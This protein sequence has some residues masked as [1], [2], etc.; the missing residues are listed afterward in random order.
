MRS[1]DKIA[2]P[3]YSELAAEALTRWS[4]LDFDAWGE[5]LADDVQYS[6]P[7]GD[8]STRT[9]LVGKKALLEWWKAWR[10]KTR[11]ESVTFQNHNETPIDVRQPRASSGLTG[12]MVFSVFSSAL[13]YPSGTVNL[14]MCWI[15]HFNGDKK[16]DRYYTYYDRHKTVELLG[17]N[18]LEAQPNSSAEAEQGLRAANE[19]FYS[20][21]NDMFK[22]E[23]DSMNAI[24]SHADDVSNQGPFG[25]RMDGWDRVRA[26]FEKEAAMKL[27]G[28]VAC[29]DLVVHAGSDMGYTVCVEV[30]ENMTAG[31]KP[32]TVRHRATNVFRMENGQ[33]RL[34]HHHTDLSPELSGAVVSKTK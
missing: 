18:L 7:D 1:K 5:M 15:A 2:P 23:L 34:I 32:V 11:V 28:R 27:G 3:L 26:Q 14:R 24:W 6:F 13:T 31:G 25:D 10:T 16:I 33:W 4:R 8:E 29:T 9:T 30:G 19:N 22:G 21:L 17:K 20:A 12:V